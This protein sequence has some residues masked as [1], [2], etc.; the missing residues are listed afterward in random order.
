MSR[1]VDL[2]RR[3]LKRVYFE[4]TRLAGRDSRALKRH[5]RAGR[6]LILNLHAVAPHSNP[7]SPALDPMLF[8]EM[9]EWLCRNARVTTLGE[10]EHAAGLDDARPAAVL[11]FDDGYRS[12][13]EYAMP[14][15]AG[16]G[17]SANQNV[18][19]SCVETGVPPWH[20]RIYDFLNSAPPALRSKLIVPGLTA[21]PPG[22]DPH[23]KERF[24]A[25]IGN[26]LKNLPPASRAPLLSSI[27]SLIGEVGLDDPTPM[28]SA[29]DVAEAAAAGHEIGAHSYS[30]E[31]M[32]FVDDAFFREDLKRC[33]DVLDGA[34]CQTTIYAF[35]NGS[36]RPDQIP[37]LRQAGIRHVLVMGQ[38]AA[39]PRG[40]VHCRIT[41]RGHYPAELHGRAAGLAKLRR[42]R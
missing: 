39:E 24:G 3:V 36:H 12:F 35:P 4:V 8:E 38:R 42:G 15:L 9:L 20:V 25:A 40:D 16:F 13:V 23:S 14:I 21:A 37:L 7:Y 32:A 33:T 26:H 10:L 30:H 22:E 34:G 18:I 11:S 6:A 5:A 28:M 17:L 1:P 31:S 41:V 2:Q 29:R 27:E 19:G